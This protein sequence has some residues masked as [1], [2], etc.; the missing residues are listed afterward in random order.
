MSAFKIFKIVLTT[1]LF[2]FLSGDQKIFSFLG[3]I[4]RIENNSVIVLIENNQHIITLKERPKSYREGL[5]V[6]IQNVNG[7]YYI[8][9]IE[10][11]ITKQK[12]ENSHSLLRKVKKRID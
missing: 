4:D 5:W 9:R 7:R 3:V 1:F 11:T 12:E 8:V 10:E 2:V 6:R